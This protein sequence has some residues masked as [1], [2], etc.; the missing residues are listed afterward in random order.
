MTELDDLR[1]QKD[2]F[3]TS[4]HSPLEPGANFEGL[5]YFPEAA[6]FRFEAPIQPSPGGEL[7]VGTSDGQ[8]RIYQRAGMVRF[9]VNGTDAQLTLLHPSAT[10][11]TSYRS[12]MQPRVKK[13]TVRADISISTWKRTGWFPS[14]ST[15]PT[16][17]IAPIR[18]PT[19]AHS[20]QPKTG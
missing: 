18:R 1:A 2:E 5:A 9:Q 8:N 7:T 14:T 11:A 17:R 16:T 15:W 13:P 6:A 3:F 10:T 20:R 4:P 12:G 19:R